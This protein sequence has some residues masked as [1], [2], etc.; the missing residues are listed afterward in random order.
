MGLNIRI[1]QPSVS[2][3]IEAKK[4]EVFLINKK[5]IYKYIMT[6]G[7]SGTLGKKGQFSFIDFCPFCGKNL[8]KFYNDVSYINEIDHIW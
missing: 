8:S 6:E 7:Y 5:N 3:N 4:R 1:I 2:F